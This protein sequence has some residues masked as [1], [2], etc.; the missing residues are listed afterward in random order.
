MSKYKKFMFWRGTPKMDHP[1]G[2][3]MFIHTIYSKKYFFKVK[4]MFK[5]Q[6]FKT[7]DFHCDV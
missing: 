2:I 6:L 3:N 5:K 1:S 7:T 4:K